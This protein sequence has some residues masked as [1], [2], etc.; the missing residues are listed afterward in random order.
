MNHPDEGTMRRMVDEP[1]LVRETDR[2]HIQSCARCTNL[3]R[4]IRVDVEVAAHTLRRAPGPVDSGAALRDVRARIAAG[5]IPASRPWYARTLD[6][7]RVKRVAA[8]AGTAGALAGAL[9]LTPAGSWAQSFVTIFQPTQ[10]QAV[11][12]ST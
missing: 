3:L 8:A 5:R 4:E 10:I 6:G 7:L 1:S 9:L 12:V 2:R 11:P